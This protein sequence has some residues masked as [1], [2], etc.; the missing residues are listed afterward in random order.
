MTKGFYIVKDFCFKNKCC[1][2]ELPIQNSAQKKIL[3]RLN[4][5]NIDEKKLLLEQQISKFE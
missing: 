3:N 1:T 5:F 4:V 2:F